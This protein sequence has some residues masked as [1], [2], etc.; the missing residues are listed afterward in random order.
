VQANNDKNRD[1]E[2]QLAIQQD[3]IK[4]V[5]DWLRQEGF[6]PQNITH[7]R[8]DAYYYGVVIITDEQK[9]N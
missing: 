4:K 3:T 1:K 6:E 8:K 2:K 5:I 7:L 9:K